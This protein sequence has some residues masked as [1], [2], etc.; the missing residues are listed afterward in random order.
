M[1]IK[2]ATMSPPDRSGHASHRKSI[3][4]YRNRFCKHKIVGTQ[5]ITETRGTSLEDQLTKR[6]DV[7]RS[8]AKGGLPRQLNRQSCRRPPKGFG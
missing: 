1:R 7:R 6:S 8:N 5:I 2:H 3:S 4:L